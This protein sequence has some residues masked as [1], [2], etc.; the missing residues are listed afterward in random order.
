MK[1]LHVAAFAALALAGGFA[2]AQVVTPPQVVNVG[3]TDLIQVVPN[4]AAQAQSKY[5]TAA[6]ISGPL[7]YKVLNS[8][9]D[10]HGDALTYTATAGVVNIFAYA[11]TS[12]I[13]SATITTEA[14]PG[15]GQREC[16]LAVGEATTT[17]TFTANTGQT[18]QAGA[19][20]IAAGVS[21][22]SI[23]ITYV[24]SLTEWFR[25]N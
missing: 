24:A 4:G 11:T 22:V 21:N 20:A 2:V 9:L 23:C 15:D 14:N 10:A 18:M 8:G 25:S 17:L 6:Q 7:G 13:T 5:A 3:P 1:L 12:A 16:Y 19:S